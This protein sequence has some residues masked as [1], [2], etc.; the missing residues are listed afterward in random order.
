MSTPAKPG[1]YSATADIPPVVVVGG[2]H[3]SASQQLC[4]GIGL[5]T[6]VTMAAR[7]VTSASLFQLYD[8]VS[9]AEQL[10]CALEAPAG[11]GYSC[12]PGWP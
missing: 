1:P 4:T 3:V 9:A 10:I 12:G 2:A 7:G 8:G 6:S 11:G 5:I